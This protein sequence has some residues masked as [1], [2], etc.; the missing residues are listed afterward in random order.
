MKKE[1]L[2]IITVKTILAVIIFTAALI[3][4]DEN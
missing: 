2:S 4:K 1:P 3:E